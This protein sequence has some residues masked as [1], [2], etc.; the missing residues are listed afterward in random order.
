M[1]YLVSFDLCSDP[2][3]T[4]SQIETH[5]VLVATMHLSQGPGNLSNEV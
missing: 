2:I 4:R 3:M 5:L 1:P